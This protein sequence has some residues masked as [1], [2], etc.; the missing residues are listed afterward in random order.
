M[1]DCP[2]TT[3][4][5]CEGRTQVTSRDVAGLKD[6][7]RGLDRN[8]FGLKQAVTASGEDRTATIYV[9]MEHLDRF[10]DVCRRVRKHMARFPGN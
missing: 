3:A 4:I 10:P 9:R 2:Y 1:T 6:L 5:F 8:L 7:Y